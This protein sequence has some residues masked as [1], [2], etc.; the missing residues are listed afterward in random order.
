MHRQ[1]TAIHISEIIPQ[2]IYKYHEENNFYSS[3]GNKSVSF[4]NSIERLTL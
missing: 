2:S 4:K 1:K 3:T